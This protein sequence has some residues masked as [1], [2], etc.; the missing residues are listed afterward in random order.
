MRTGL[1]AKYEN[2]LDQHLKN[3]ELLFLDIHFS[4]LC[5]LA[6]RTC[7]PITSTSWIKDATLLKTYNGPSHEEAVLKSRE[8]VKQKIKTLTELKLKLDVLHLTGGEL[9]LLD[10]VFEYLK[11]C[12]QKSKKNT[13]LYITTNL[14]SVATKTN[15]INFLEG[16]KNLELLCSIDAIGSLNDFI[17]H[18]SRWDKVLDGLNLIRKK[19]SHANIVIQPTIS[20]LNIFHLEEYLA[21]LKNDM[22]QLAFNFILLDRPSYYSI[23]QLDPELKNRARESLKKLQILYPSLQNEFDKI[24]EMLENSNESK[25]EQFHSITRRLDFLRGESF[26]KFYPDIF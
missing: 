24:I 18:G 16:W 10:E 1:N 25:M 4:N 19:L 17:R 5:D 12:D 3:P 13:T 21:F 23:K 7:R 11:N 20:I 9:F 2:T 6:C 15:S 14:N 22:P 8:L 26:Y